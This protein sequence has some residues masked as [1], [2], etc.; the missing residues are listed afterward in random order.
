MRFRRA[1][2]ENVATG[3]GWEFART[4]VSAKVDQRT[5]LELVNAVL[6]GYSWPLCIP[7]LANSKHRRRCS[8]TCAGR[9]LDRASARSRFVWPLPGR[10]APAVPRRGV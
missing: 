3:H 7:R 6:K 9:R 10:G 4:V 1:H 5:V 2:V 8:I